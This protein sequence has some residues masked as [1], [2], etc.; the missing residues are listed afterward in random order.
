MPKPLLDVSNITCHYGSFLALRDVTLTVLPSE[1][2]VIVGPSGSG[3]TSLLRC[4]SG[5]EKPS[6]GTIKVRKHAE[7]SAQHLVG[8]V[9]QNFN[10]WPHLTI[11]ENLTLPQR[12]ILRAP[13]QQADE[14]A[15]EMLATLGLSEQAAKYP[16]ALSGGQKQRAAIG[17]AL[18]MR[19]S[20][21]LF[22]EPTSALDPEMMKSVIG[23][24]RSL[25]AAGLANIIVTHDMKFAA[26]IA[27]RVIFMEQGCIAAEGTS[28]D[29]TAGNMGERANDFLAHLS[30]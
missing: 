16:H 7:D 12:V 25:A 14:Q 5:L 24:I 15:R 8:M 23:L 6:S 10:L 20:V 28:S 27:D 1:T 11:L 18:V 3:K 30:H 26:A 17:R 9:F 22:D 2:V 4:L 13:P 29:F 21:L 19:P